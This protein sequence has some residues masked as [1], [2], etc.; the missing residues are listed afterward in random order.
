MFFQFLGWNVY[1]KPETI[2]K[3]TYESCKQ[4]DMLYRENAC[5]LLP[6]VIQVERGKC[7]IGK[8]RSLKQIFI[9]KN[10][11]LIWE[12]EKINDAWNITETS[13]N[14]N[15]C[16]HNTTLSLYFTDMLP[17]YCFWKWGFVFALMGLRQRWDSL[18][19]FIT[20]Y[21]SVSGELWI[22]MR[23]VP[24]LIGF[25]P[26]SLFKSK[27]YRRFALLVNRA[28][29][30]IQGR[31]GMFSTKAAPG[32]IKTWKNVCSP[33][34]AFVERMPVLRFCH[35]LL[36]VN[37]LNVKCKNS[38]KKSGGKKRLTMPKRQIYPQRLY[39]WITRPHV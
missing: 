20:C 5:I 38:L 14:W 34:A 31:V 27:V 24:F 10:L 29:Y 1:H 11:Y 4:T 39:Q 23:A 17:L 18:W 13:L 19:L 8:N 32:S 16:S 6:T 36:K 3:I 25:D 35:F 2:L 21:S 26:G 30:Q 9:F 12:G 22:F 15:N 28:A 37:D 33:Q 7:Y